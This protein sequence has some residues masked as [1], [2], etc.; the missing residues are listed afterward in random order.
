MR[1]ELSRKAD[2]AIRAALVLA[3]HGGEE[4]V[5]AATIVAGA[6]IP[7]PFARHVLSDLAKAGVITSKEGAGGGYRLAR[8]ASEVSLLD[9][10]EAIEG[11]LQSKRCAVRGLPCNPQNPC[12]VHSGWAAAQEAMRA[13]L[14]TSSIAGMLDG[15]IS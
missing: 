4:L 3:R 2:Y 12:L 6:G 5:P 13:S 11:R 7:P 1:M 14:A 15:A 8:P 9:I 10:V